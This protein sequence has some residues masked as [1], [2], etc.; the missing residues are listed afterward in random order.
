MQAHAW[1]YSKHACCSQ[2]PLSALAPVRAW[3]VEQAGSVKLS[4]FA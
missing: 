3:M 1:A 2:S 4:E